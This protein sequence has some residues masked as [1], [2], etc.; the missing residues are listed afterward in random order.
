MG[1]MKEDI[2]VVGVSEENTQDIISWSRMIWYENP[3]EG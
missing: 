1:V 2:R 3:R